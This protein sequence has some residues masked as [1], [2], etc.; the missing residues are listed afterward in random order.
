M[1]RVTLEALLALLIVTF[2]AMVAFLSGV[3]VLVAALFL[4]V[5]VWVVKGIFAPPR[6]H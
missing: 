6:T 2:L 5:L 4:G 1:L 3:G